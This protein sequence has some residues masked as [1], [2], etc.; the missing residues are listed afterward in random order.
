MPLL[1]DRDS[2]GTVDETI[3]LT[4]EEKVATA[5]PKLSAQAVTG[6]KIKVSWPAAAA[7]FILEANSTLSST[8]WTAVPANQLA[9]EGANRVF[10]ESGSGS[11]RFYRLRKN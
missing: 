9:T 4:D 6:G 11:T 10:T 5:G 1:I 2:N 8:G 7:D 3:Q